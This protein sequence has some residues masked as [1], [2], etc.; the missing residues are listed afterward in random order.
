MAL[1]DAGSSLSRAPGLQDVA[2]AASV[3]DTT[4]APSS[5]SRG[6]SRAKTFA[7]R[8]YQR[9]PHAR[10]GRR[11]TFHAR[12]WARHRRAIKAERMPASCLQNRGEHNFGA[13]PSK[14]R[15]L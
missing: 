15:S 12:L 14:E 4:Y 1:S 9:A 2:A 13:M 5:L 8:V 3:A 10:F 11:P 6:R 7:V